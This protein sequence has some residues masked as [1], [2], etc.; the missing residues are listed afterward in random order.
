LVSV[1]GKTKI[2][3]NARSST[4]IIITIY[5]DYIAYQRP[6]LLVLSIKYFIMFLK[7]ISFTKNLDCEIQ[8]LDSIDYQ[9]IVFRVKDFTDECDF[10]FKSSDNSYKVK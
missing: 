5:S 7:F 10:L 6:T 4:L 9:V 3:N 2:I 1:K 8:K